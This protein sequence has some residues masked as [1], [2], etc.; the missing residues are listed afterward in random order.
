MAIYHFSMKNISRGKG[1]SATASAAYR[2]GDK[3]Y[4]ERYGKY[5]HYLREVKPD[6]FILKPKHAPDWTLDR[7]KLW[8]EV[9]RIEK[10]KD[11]RLSKEV[12]VALPKE[13]SHD[14][15]KELI[16]EFC[17][18]NFVN[19][20]MVADISIHRDNENNP[21][22]HVM[23][24]IRP[25]N[26]NGEW[27][28]T[29][30]ITKY[31]F[32]E[33]GNHILTPK[34]NRKNIKTDMIDSST[35][36]LIRLRKEW[37]DITNKYLKMNGIN[38][39]VSEKSYED[40][41]VKKIPTIH[42]G[43]KAIQMGDKSERVQY[44]NEVKKYNN[45]VIK[46]N[47]YKKEI[48]DVKE[49]EKLTRHFSPKDK[50]QLSTVAKKLNVFVNFD[51]IM[52]KKIQLS[53]WEKSELFKSE[54]NR[55]NKENINEIT[56]QKEAVMIADEILNKEANKFIEKHYKHYLKD[57]MELTN[58]QKLYITDLSVKENK[59]MNNEEFKDAV[60][61]SSNKEFYES[62]KTITRD[63]FKSYL[64][65]SKKLNTYEN[66][67]KELVDKYNVDFKDKS[68]V[69]KLSDK[70]LNELRL[71][72]VRVNN[73]KNAMSFVS[74]YYDKR[75]DEMYPDI[76]KKL[77]KNMSV[78]EKEI[79]VSSFD[80]YERAL[81]Y[82]EIKN[83]KDNPPSKYSMDVKESVID[84]MKRYNSID[85]DNTTYWKDAERNSREK[86]SIDSQIKKQFPEIFGEDASPAME[87]FFYS[88]LA[89]MSDE[90][91]E[92]VSKFISN[93]NPKSEDIDNYYMMSDYRKV[94]GL[95]KLLSSG[96]SSVN[97]TLNQIDFDERDKVAEMDRLQKKVA[98]RNRRKSGLD[99]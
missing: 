97:R 21:H 12:V 24:T 46:L 59:I 8:N 31:L 72:T 23:L 77:H 96:F 63:A 92:I 6:S 36:T 14:T 57:G 28:K 15:Q 70:Q 55:E 42:E 9:E 5:N 2:S 89:S 75:I 79:I 74:D 51:S 65:L 39:T 3:L 22:A 73:T 84:K 94:G 91:K 53:H 34:G 95:N 13:L 38:Q 30:T 90:S 68:S 93:E 62:I 1:Q 66:N 4:S 19:A 37:A 49:V 43:Y 50:K 16:K 10:R 99:R 54:F 20:G 29:K 82:K 88:E 78:H 58:Y 47:K 17:Q 83:L 45:N 56:N 26:E 27:S 85:T 52:K 25:F 64:D 11:A 48:E 7:E 98:Y 41:G 60:Y 67:L 18:D 87:Q 32:D 61:V 86:N 71:A 69:D 81:S 76:S 40:L 44:N 35:E 33:E 80:Y